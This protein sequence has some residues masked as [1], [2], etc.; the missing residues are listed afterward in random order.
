MIDVST[1][2]R[3]DSSASASVTFAISPSK[4]L[5][6]LPICASRFFSCRLSSR[7]RTCFSRFSAAVRSLTSASRAVT[8]SSRSRCAGERGSVGRSSIAEPIA[9]STRA[10]VLSV[11]ASSPIAW[12]KRRARSALTR[13]S[14]SRPARLSSKSRCHGPVDSYTTRGADAPI[15]SASCANPAASLANRAA[16]PVACRWTSRAAFEMS[17][18]TAS[19]V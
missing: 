19:R 3:R 4:A 10:S 11:F 6:C 16:S 14:G 12:A 13:A 15:Q 7:W 2:M 8:S 17:T 5:I 1:S 9:A 18:P